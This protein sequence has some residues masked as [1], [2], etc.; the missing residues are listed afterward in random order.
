LDIGSPA[1]LLENYLKNMN[2]NPYL[3]DPWIYPENNE[4][5]KNSVYFVSSRHDEFK[6]LSKIEKSIIIDPWRFVEKTHP[7]SKIIKIGI[8]IIG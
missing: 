5:P 8:N 4:L 7:T 3:I 2:F 6:D 1:R